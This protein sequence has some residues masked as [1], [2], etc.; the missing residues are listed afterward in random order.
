MHAK[1]YQVVREKNNVYNGCTIQ[2]RKPCVE[3]EVEMHFYE[4]QKRK[5]MFASIF[6]LPLE[7][8][9]VHQTKFNSCS[10]Y[11]C[12]KSQNKSTRKKF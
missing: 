6:I 5:D 7:S 9:L 3:R 4:I 10:M 8:F 12:W 2:S 11:A 1:S